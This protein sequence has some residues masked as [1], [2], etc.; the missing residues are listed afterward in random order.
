MPGSFTSWK[1]I[2]VA[3]PSAPTIRTAVLTYGALQMQTTYLL[4]YVTSLRC[5][6][7][8]GYAW[9]EATVR[10]RQAASESDLRATVSVGL[11]S[12]S[13]G[14]WLAGRGVTNGESHGG[15]LE[16]HAA[17]ITLCS[18]D[19]LK[20]ALWLLQHPTYVSTH[21]LPQPHTYMPTPTY[22]HTSTGSNA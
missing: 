22:S 8:V 19:R 15:T 10:R 9:K 16:H 2:Y 4:A 7:R 20:Q 21:T 18:P 11:C 12:A 6:C 13:S 17:H 1:Y 3:T 14:L 5:V